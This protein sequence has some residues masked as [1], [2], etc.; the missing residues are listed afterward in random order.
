MMPG[1]D[2]SKYTWAVANGR[3]MLRALREAAG[4]SQMDVMLRLSDA[5][6]R[7]DQAHIQKIESG[8]IKRPTA[9]TLDAILTVGLQ[10]PYRVRSDVLAA[11]G[12]Q[13][14]WELPTAEEIELELKLDGGEVMCAIWPAYLIDQAQRI[15]AWNPLFPR[16]LGGA[17]DD[18]ANEG[19]IGLTVLDILFNPA[20]GT[21]RQIANSGTFV[22][23]IVGWF[24]TMTRQY[25]QDP[26]F[27]EFMA[28]A[29]TWPGFTEIWDQIPE[30]PQ[31][32]LRTHS[33]VPV[34]IQVPGLSKPLLFRPVHVPMSFDPRFA[35]LHLMPLNA[36]T[37]TV[38]AAWAEEAT[39]G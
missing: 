11:F 15:W 1:R 6:V 9:S 33:T 5:G 21:H 26:W 28:R 19:F 8:A 7:V 38:C 20:V 16:L 39:T 36:E 18:P 2:A 25:W 35:V 12:Y 30:G 13:L 14:R 24:K 4:L 23:V 10:V 32:L 3:E 34:E 37:Q 29:R 22:P 17:S 27:H 31:L